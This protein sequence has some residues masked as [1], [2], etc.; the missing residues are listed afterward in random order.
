MFIQRF[1]PEKGFFLSSGNLFLN[2]FLILA[3]GEGYFSLMKT[4]NLLESFFLQVETVAAMSGNQVL[5][6]ELILAGEN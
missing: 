1:L 2:K 4:V 5:K 3:V 6:T